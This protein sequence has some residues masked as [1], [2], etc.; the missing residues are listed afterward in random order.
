MLETLKIKNSNKQG[1]QFYHIPS[2]TTAALQN[3]SRNYCLQYD[4]LNPV[5]YYLHFKICSVNVVH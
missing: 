2:K 5:I 1:N 4:K 3:M